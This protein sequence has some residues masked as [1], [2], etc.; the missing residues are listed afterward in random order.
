MKNSHY[1]RVKKRSFHSTEFLIDGECGLYIEDYFHEMVSLER[2]RSER[3]GRPFLL[4]LIDIKEVHYAGEIKEAVKK[5]CSAL[6]ALTRETDVRGWHEHNFVIGVI[7]TEV[8]N[9]DIEPIKKKVISGLNDARS[10][11]PLMLEKTRVSFHI[12]PEEAAKGAKL[13]PDLTIYPD[14]AKK[15]PIRQKDLNLKRAIDILGAVLALIIFSPLFA[16]IPVMIKLSSKGPVIFRQKRIGALGAPFT[17]LKF[18]S[19]YSGTDENIHSEYIRKLIKEEAAYSGGE[20]GKVYKIKD[21]PRVTPIG[22]VL[23]KTSLDE[24]PQFINVLKGEMSLVGPRPPIPYEIGNYE[25]WHLRRVLEAK[26]GITGLWQV[27]GR[28][29]TT[30]NEMVRMD[31]KYIKERSL[32]LDLKLILKTPWSMLTSRGAY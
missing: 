32:W 26:P 1:R 27:K 20:G 12:F 5:I 8:S 28:S 31:L 9:N 13:P 22:K 3:S 4:M 14:L 24:L 30:F 25:P 2:K 16:V 11:G 18:R 17:F 29:K 19:M 10:I 6:T 7:F 21:D 23:R 15:T